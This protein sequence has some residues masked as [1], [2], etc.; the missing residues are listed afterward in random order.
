MRDNFER[1]GGY[2][3]LDTMKRAINKW[4][5]PYMS[6]VMYNEMR[7]V[8]I[9]CEGIMVGEREAAYQFMCDF[10]LENSPGRRAEDVSV[11]TGDGFFNQSMVH[12]FG[13]T[14]A[15]FI[16][17]WHHLFK[18]GL[19]EHFGEGGCN[20]IRGQLSQMIKAKEETYFNNALTNARTTLQN[21]ASGRDLELEKKLE[22]F[23]N[24]KHT[25]AAYCL[26]KIK[27]TKGFMDRPCLSRIIQVR[28]A[29]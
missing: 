4:L 16:A 9:G 28:Y 15:S 22:E 29:T 11:V 14:E 2:I 27:G 23:A 5:W 26:D 10:V 12:K 17:D 8:C 19:N 3:S 1:F 25:Y 20:H 13:F 18:D 24:N 7:T 6:V 21:L